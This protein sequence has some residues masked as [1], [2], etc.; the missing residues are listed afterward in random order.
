MQARATPAMV[1]VSS[2]STAGQPEPSDR[3]HATTLS[4]PR[5]SADTSAFSAANRPSSAPPSRSIALPRGH[6]SG[7]RGAAQGPDLAAD[8]ALALDPVRLAERA[9]LVPDPWQAQVL[10]STAPRVL[11]NCSRQSGKSTV[12]AVLAMHTALYQPGSLTLLLSPSERQSK[13]LFRKV[14]DCYLAAGRPEPP[15]SETTL[16]LELENGSRV[17]ALPGSEASIRGF[18][19]V[20]LLVVD[21]ASRV[22]DELYYA[23]RPMLA[24][25]GG[26]LIALSTPWG[27]RGW[28]HREWTE[29]GDG[30]ERVEVPATAC[31]RIPTTFL[32]EER[33]A[34]PEFVFAQEYGC[35]FRETIDQLFSYDDVMGTLSDDVAPLFPSTPAPTRGL[36]SDYFA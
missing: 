24:V 15:E 7:G 9:G 21:E 11:L 25:S 5:M 6:L 34:L 10:R 30:W 4:S 13:E 14:L 17:I 35:E 18:S 29:G 16:W 32:E 36:L 1:G 8:L 26:R 3:T 27:R 19:G 33:R 20:T 12:S 31:P 2:G 22:A 23:V 28:W